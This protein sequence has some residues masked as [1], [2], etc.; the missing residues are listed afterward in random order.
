[1]TTYFSLLQH[2]GWRVRSLLGRPCRDEAEI[3]YRI[4][5]LPSAATNAPFRFPW[6]EISYVSAS[7]LRGQ[8][9]EI[10]VKRHYAFKASNEA[11]VIIDAGG[12]IGMSAIWL[13][14]TYPKSQITVYEADPTLAT[15]LKENLTAARIS[16]VDVQNAAV[17]DKD[18]VVAF[19]N[20][21]QDKGLISSN[22]QIQIRSIDLALHLP[23]RVDLLKL[24]IEGAEFPV[25]RRLSETGAIDRVQNLV[26]EFHV[27]RSDFDA[28]LTAFRQLRE[29]GMQ[30]SVTSA[31]GTWLGVAD[32]ASTFD[33][34]GTD[35]IL[36]EVYAWR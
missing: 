20:R 25:I 22:G 27:R 16:D 28:C 6:G 12:N 36:M 32:A 11:P 19:D 13:R 21:G 35:Q 1:M 18:G 30:V 4:N 23:A 34:V 5:R 17:W 29:A 9:Y 10:F 33:I 3:S 14:Q 8:F 7:D 24:D 26:A 31:L 2:L 15:I